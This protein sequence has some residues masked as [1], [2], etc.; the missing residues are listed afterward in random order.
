MASFTPFPSGIRTI[1][2]VVFGWNYI[3]EKNVIIGELYSHNL[4]IA[5]FCESNNMASRVPW[6]GFCGLCSSSSP[7]WIS[8]VALLD[9]ISN[10]EIFYLV[11]CQLIEMTRYCTVVWINSCFCTLLVDI[12]SNSICDA[13]HLFFTPSHCKACQELVNDLLSYWTITLLIF[14]L[15]LITMGKADSIIGKIE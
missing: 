11:I 6:M 13:I 12:W 5:G 15:E 7:N 1:S 10:D 2:S 14:I 9:S 3:W 8:L 4:P